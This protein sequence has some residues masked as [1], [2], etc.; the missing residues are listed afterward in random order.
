MVDAGFARQFRVEG[1]GNHVALAHGHDAPVR[2][3]RQHLDAG[4]HSID[5]RGADEDR[6]HRPITKDRHR[7]I[8]L[9]G[10]DLP[11]ERVALDRDVEQREDRL[12]AAGY[13]LRQKDHPRTRAE[14]RGSRPCQLHDRLSKPPAGDELA[15]GRTL[16]AG[17]DQPGNALEVP[18]QA[19]QNGLYADGPKGPDMLDDGAVERQ[20][21]NSHYALRVRMSPDRPMRPATPKLMRSISLL[22]AADRQSLRLRDGDCRDAAHRAAKA[23]GDLG[24]NLWVVEVERGLDDRLGRPGWVLALEDPRSYE[25][26]LSPEPVSYT[27]PEPTRLGM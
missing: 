11:A 18:R 7:Q 9:E 24:D 6:M 21:A 4:P 23:F 27:H 25:H 10:V 8:R 19:H 26:A 15:H 1:E 20:Y 12:F 22:P 2:E 13:L 5:D 14:D 17:K 16:A 3:S